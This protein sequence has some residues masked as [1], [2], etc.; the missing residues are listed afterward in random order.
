MTSVPIRDP[1]A[2]HL[3]CCRLGDRDFLDMLLLDRDFTNNRCD[4]A[5][6][7]SF[8]DLRG[9][10]FIRELHVVLNVP[11]DLTHGDESI[12]S[13]R[14]GTDSVHRALPSLRQ[15]CTELDRAVPP[16][17]SSDL[18]SSRRRC[19]DRR[20]LTPSLKQQGSC[21]SSRLEHPSR[22]RSLPAARHAGRLSE[23]GVPRAGGSR[24]SR[25]TC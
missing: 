25:A 4:G 6:G 8:V 18:M 16:G 19:H 23:F 11:Q 21:W 14:R 17:T 15:L 24:D 22:A 7:N 5:G 13:R 12:S 2:D 9:G 3:G 20:D 1:L 10:R